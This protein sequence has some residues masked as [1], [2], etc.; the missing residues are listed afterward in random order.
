M[1]TKYKY[2]ILLIVT[3]LSSVFIY[4]YIEANE[5]VTYEISVLDNQK[6][7]EKGLKSDNDYSIDNPKVILNPYNISPLTALVIFKTSDLASTEVIIK[8]RDGD[9]DIINTFVPSKVH[10]IPIYGLYADYDNTVIIKSSGEEKVL[11]I[12]TEALTEGLKNARV[13]DNDDEFLFTTSD[14]G[15]PVAYDKNGNVRWYLT[16][17]FKFDFTRLSNGYILLGNSELMKTPYYSSSL[18]EMDLLGKI[19]FEYLIPDGYHHDVYEMTNGNFLVLSNDFESGTLEDVIVEIDRDS[20]EIIKSFN[21]YDLFPNDNGKNWID[22]NSVIYDSSTN[23][24]FTV[25]SHINSIINL[26]YNT[27]EIN[28]TIGNTKKALNPLNNPSMPIS[29]KGLVLTDDGIAF[30]STKENNDYFIRYK[31]DNNNRTF[32][33][34]ENINLGDK[35]DNVTMDYNDGIFIVT[36][37]NIIQKIDNNVTDL[38]NCDNNLYSAKKS[39]MYTGDIYMLNDVVKLGNLGITPTTKGGPVIIHKVDKDIY[40]KYDLSLIQN[41]NRLVVSGTFKKG[42]KVQ[43]VLDNVL[44][45]ETYDVDVLEG[46]KTSEGKY[47]TQTYINKEGIYGKHYIYLRIN[48][49]VYKLQKYIVS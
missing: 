8:G 27:G 1:K 41:S 49:K 38:M 40:K 20:G 9:E 17:N 2:L 5:A 6:E 3:L 23:S 32:E 16:K 7:I 21:L 35:A 10:Y 29:P 34:L 37:D 25:G 44:S 30:I 36:R 39:S 46:K 48:G 26:D 22:L 11:N 47:K 18:Y 24:I 33:E 28:Y 14:D 31:I 12:K 13:L 19:Y 15:Y 43:V 42:D 4:Y 45:K